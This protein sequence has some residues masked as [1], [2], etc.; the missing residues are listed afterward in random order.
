VINRLIE[1]LKEAQGRVAEVSE[2]KKKAEQRYI[3]ARKSQKLF[4]PGFFVRFTS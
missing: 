2:V 4:V 1:D 3:T